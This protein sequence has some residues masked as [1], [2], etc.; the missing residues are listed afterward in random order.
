QKCWRLATAMESFLLTIG[1]GLMRFVPGRPGR[2]L[3]SHREI[4]ARNIFKYWKANGGTGADR[5][6]Y[7]CRIGRHNSVRG[8]RVGQD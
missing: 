1:Q 8:L 4:Y 3:L 2:R 5:G 6:L 7:I